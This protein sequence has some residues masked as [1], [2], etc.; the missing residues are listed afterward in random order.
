MTT[1]TDH[2]T[3]ARMCVGCSERDDAVALVRLVIGPDG[4]IAVDAKGGSFGRGAHVHASP[5]CLKKAAKSG[6]L[7]AFKGKAKTTEAELSR[8][9]AVAMDR[10][11][12]GL[13]A[14]SLRARALAIGSDAVSAACRAGEAKLVVVAR[15][16]AAAAQLGE[17]QRA[18]A[19]GRAVA[20]S[21][22]ERLGRLV[23]S[24][25]PVAVVAIERQ[26]IADSIRDAV[27]AMDACVGVARIEPVAADSI[28][29]LERGA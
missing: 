16:A 9:I 10:R 27:H 18:V 21:D 25:D 6:L 1:T 17:V 29:T 23:R 7:R 5:S 19:E 20:W 11:I 13:L 26:T 4:S 22:K 8:S 14:S 24:R 3:T 28:E 12:E 2:E 15:D